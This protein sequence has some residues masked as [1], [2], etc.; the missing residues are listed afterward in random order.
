MLTKRN[1]KDS[2]N[3][4]ILTGGGAR[5]AY[6]VGVL[7]AISKFVPRNHG[8]PFPIICGTSAGAI[9]TTA[10]A[11]YSS[12][13]HLGV[14][15]LEWVWKNINTSRVYHSDGIR[16]FSHLAKGMLASFQADYANKSARS[17][18]NNAPLRDML[19]MVVDFKRI[20]ANIIRG[21]LSAVS[22]TASSYSNGDSISFYQS[23]ESISPWFRAKR[24]GE[25]CQINS[26][27]LMASAAIPLVFPSIKIRQEHYGDGSIHQLSPLSPAIH[28]GGENLFIIGV[29]QPKAPLHSKVNNPHPPTTSTVAGHLLDTIFS[30]TLHSDIE[31]LERINE[32]IKLIPPKVRK[33]KDGLKPISS[34]L[35]N[36]S[37]DF[38]AIAVDYFS[39]L[40]LSIRLLLRSVGISND[41]ES[42]IV[43]YLLFEKNYCRQ[44]I[45][46]G[47][48]D[49]MEQET[50]IRKFL[51]L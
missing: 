3:A 27:H 15:K 51:S 29:D 46:L 12:C 39:D 4:L 45:K 19:N 20:D 42:S 40:P 22:I 38:N 9:N 8:I 6:Q 17:L 14:K 18:L 44:L 1:Y 13:F 32:T 23:E 36:P 21:Y 37:H 49:A 48:E 50:A 28:L 5:A 43:S 11:C 24:R 33:E 34:F 30:D 26:E 7:S 16:V 10:L 35:I 25:P 41:S 31:R 2:K 47:F